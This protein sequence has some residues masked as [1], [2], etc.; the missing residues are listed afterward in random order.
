MIGDE[1]RSRWVG[2]DGKPASVVGII[3]GSAAAVCLVLCMNGLKS[4]IRI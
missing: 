2:F 4:T 1:P 3:I